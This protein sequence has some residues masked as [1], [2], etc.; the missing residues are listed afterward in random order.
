MARRTAGPVDPD[1]VEDGTRVQHVTWTTSTGQPQRGTVIVRRAW[2][3]PERWREI[4]WDGAPTTTR[5]D[6][7]LADHLVRIR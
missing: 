2:S 5:L 6:A 1:R 3:T 4:S 7:Q